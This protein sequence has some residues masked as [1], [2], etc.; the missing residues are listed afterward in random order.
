M[1]RRQT[2]YLYNNSFRVLYLRAIEL[3]LK[4]RGGKIYI[5]EAQIDNSAV[6][7]WLETSTSYKPCTNRS[8]SHW[9]PFFTTTTAGSPY[10]RPGLQY[11]WL[12]SWGLQVTPLWQVSSTTS[13]SRIVCGCMQVTATELILEH[14]MHWLKIKWDHTCIIIHVDSARIHFY[15]AFQ[16][17]FARLGVSTHSN[18]H[19]VG[20]HIFTFRILSG[21][22][23]N[24][25]MCPSA[26]FLW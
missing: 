2:F 17:R 4:V 6:V 19:G 24:T 16:V 8:P 7:S 1:K 10:P 15:L 14:D 12:L 25:K 5:F 22:E 23:R 3:F 21:I 26:S 18:S 13:F 20:K 9:H 11:I